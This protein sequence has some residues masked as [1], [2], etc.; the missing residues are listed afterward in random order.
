MIAFM[1]AHAA[2]DG[3]NALFPP[4]LP[5]IREYYNLSYSELGGFMTLYRFFGGILQIPVGYLAYYIPSMTIM[6]S[7]LLWLSIGLL[8]STFAKN[9]WALASS[10]S[11]AGI[12]A[13]TY[14]PL[15][16][17]TLSKIFKKEILG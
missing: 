12:G 15:S 5:L 2:N 17:S 7:G 1:L 13:S 6:V 4:L 10:F 14:H 16:F 8:L 9:Y 3:F 11:I